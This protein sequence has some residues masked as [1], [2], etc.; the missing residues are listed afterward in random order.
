VEPSVVRHRAEPSRHMRTGILLR[1]LS[2]AAVLLAACSSGPPPL[3]NGGEPGNQCVPFAQGRPVTMGL[4]VLENRGSATVRIESIVL[5]SV[6]GMTM[7]RSSWLVPT[8]HDP[9]NGDEVAVGAGWPY[10]PPNAPEWPHRKPAIGGTIRP[11]QDLSL[12]FGLV[13]TTSKA[14]TSAGPLITYTASGNTYSLQEKITLTVAA[15]CT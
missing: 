2:A 15:R 12:A 4:F 10:P 5:P 7:T 9:E 8:Y 11:G 1:A 13:R 14:G 3:G 6:H